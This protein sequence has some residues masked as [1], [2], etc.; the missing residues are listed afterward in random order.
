MAN[1]SFRMAGTGDWQNLL[2]NEETRQLYARIYPDGAL[3]KDIDD[4]FTK[5]IMFWQQAGIATI[6]GQQV[7]PLGPIMTDHDLE[8]L[9]DWFRDISNCMSGAIQRQLP[10]YRLLA[11]TMCG[12]ATPKHKVD[13]VVTILTCAQALDIWSFRVLR[14]ELIGHYPKRGSAGRFFFWGYAFSGGPENIFGVSTY[15]RGETVRL[16]IIRSHRLDRGILPALLRQADMMTYLTALCFPDRVAPKEY[17]LPDK[18]EDIVHRLREV[19][20]LKPENPPR[21][22]IPILPDRDIESASQLHRRVSAEILHA[23]TTQMG[24]L[25]DLTRRCSFAGCFLVD[26]LSMIFHLAY[27]YAADNLIITGSIPDFPN[28][29]SGEWGVWLHPF[30]Q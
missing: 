7:V 20:L 12:S 13:N 27:S 24:Q 25:Q 8:I 14:R 9:A 1:I 29:A 6:V 26:V 11:E 17:L 3:L 28:R 30:G 4:S 16:S 15:G 18:A 19:H 23:F 22:A 5:T 10:D 2:P 21:L